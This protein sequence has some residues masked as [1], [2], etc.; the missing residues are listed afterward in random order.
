M[1]ILITGAGGYIGSN[2]MKYLGGCG[3]DVTGIVRNGRFN[4]NEKYAYCDL[5]GHIELNT[6]F[7]LII[8]AA[9]INPRRC[10]T[11]NDYVEGNIIT[12]H[13][14]ID[15]ANKNDISKLLFFGTVTSYGQI[16]NILDMHK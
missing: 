16:N 15:Y 4:E 9:A 6:G 7:D 11:L 3:H 5:R 14:I 8:H 13:N 10:Y 1:K 12:T 2:L